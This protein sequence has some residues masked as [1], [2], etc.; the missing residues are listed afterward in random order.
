MPSVRVD[1]TA[2]VVEAATKQAKASK[3]STTIHDWFDIRQ[4]YLQLRQRG[5]QVTWLVRARGRSQKIG[6]AN[7]IR[8]EYDRGYLSIKQALNRAAEVYAGI[9]APPKPA[10]AGDPPPAWT[11]A[12]LDREYQASLLE[13]R[14][15]AGR[16]KPPSKGTQDDVRLA[17]AKAPVAALA[18]TALT[19]HLARPDAGRRPGAH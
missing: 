8:G 4:H 13:P 5:K 11:W 1:I 19:T 16:V 17:L 14:W 6:V 15:R 3:D 2:A 18:P 12:D 10:S 9:E 7:E